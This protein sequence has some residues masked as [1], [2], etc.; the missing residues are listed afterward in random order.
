M[1]EWRDNELY[2]GPVS[3]V[4]GISIEPG[5]FNAIFHGYIEDYDENM[6]INF[7]ESKDWLEEQLKTWLSTRGLVH[8]PEGFVLVPKEPT[9]ERVQMAVKKMLS[10]PFH[11]PVDEVKGLYKVLIG[12]DNG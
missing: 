10:A 6:F 2:C 1:I 4:G 9:E 7:Q 11:D 3:V 8:I 5:G 12:A